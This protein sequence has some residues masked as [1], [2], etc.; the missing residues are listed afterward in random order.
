MQKF[1]LMIITAPDSEFI[2][3]RAHEIAIPSLDLE[4][5]PVT[6]WLN[7]RLYLLE[8]AKKRSRKQIYD[9]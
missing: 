3:S 9:Q 4:R 2:L 5:V 1:P 6:T 8:Q 7:L